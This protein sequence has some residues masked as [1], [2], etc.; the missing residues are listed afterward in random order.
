LWMN[1]LMSIFLFRRKK[2]F[3]FWAILTFEMLWKLC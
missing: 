3:S 1:I 2:R